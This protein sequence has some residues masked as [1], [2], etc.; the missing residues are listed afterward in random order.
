MKKYLN[1]SKCFQILKESYQNYESHEIYI[2]KSQKSFINDKIQ[3]SYVQCNLK[4]IKK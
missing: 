3:S 1:S 4:E 2:Y